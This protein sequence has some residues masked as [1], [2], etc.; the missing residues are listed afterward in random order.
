M[1]ENQIYDYRL[2]PQAVDYLRETA[3][4]A[5]F[6]AIIGFIGIAFLVLFAFFA[7]TMMSTFS[8]LGNNPELGSMGGMIT[9]I[10]LVIAVLYFFPV[11]YLY[12]FASRM[13]DALRM[14]SADTMTA[15]FESLKSHY[16]FM[17]IFT[18]V[19]LSIYLL[20]FLIAIIGGAALASM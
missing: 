10:Y 4:W 13:K 19:I 15:S 16:K 9:I 12:R 8:S 7:G 3:K 17:G 6:L 2:E 11:M 5:Q 14:N 18:I 20:I 1:E